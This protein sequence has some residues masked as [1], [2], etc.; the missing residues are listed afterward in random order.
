MYNPTIKPEYFKFDAKKAVQKKLCTT[1]DL[2]LLVEQDMQVLHYDIVVRIRCANNF[3]D[4]T[5]NYIYPRHYIEKWVPE[6]KYYLFGMLKES[7]VIGTCGRGYTIRQQ[8][9]QFTE[10]EHSRLDYMNWDMILDND[11]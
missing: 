3:E 10:E 8:T 5:E 11:L 9:K 7:G 2:R 6:D 1:A 4:I